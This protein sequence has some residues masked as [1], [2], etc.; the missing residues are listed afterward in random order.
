MPELRVAVVLSPSPKPTTLD[1]KETGANTFSYLALPLLN[2]AQRGR[3][4]RQR[5]QR[6]PTLSSRSFHFF[7]LRSLVRSSEGSKLSQP[8]PTTKYT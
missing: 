2:N 8:P 6:K 1:V 7:S 3:S 5:A 4:A